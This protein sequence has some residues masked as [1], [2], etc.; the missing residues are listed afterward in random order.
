MR[1]NLSRV[2]S[3]SCVF[4]VM[5]LFPNAYAQEKKEEE[6]KPANEIFGL[7]AEKRKKADMVAA[8]NNMKQLGILLLE[9]DNDYGAYPSD[10]AA[11][12]DLELKSY[13]GKFSN[14]YL[15]QLLA[16]GYIDSEEIF[17]AKGG[18]KT[19]KNPDNVYKTKA[20]TLEA[21]ECGFSYVKGLSSFDR[22]ATPVL[23]APMTGEGFKFDPKPYNGKAIVLNVDGSV[24]RYDIDA[25]GDVILPNGKNLFEGGKDSVWGKHDLDAKGLLFPK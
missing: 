24:V 6:K 10:G 18:S 12:R 5:G 23:L 4:L 19:K 14:D 25:N 3:V 17:Y 1:M 2:R 8:V 20:T 16:A 11:N 13:Q 9:F 7:I 21:G 15:G 22:A